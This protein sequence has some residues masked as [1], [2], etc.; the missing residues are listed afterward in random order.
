MKH[1]MNHA[2]MRAKRLKLVIKTFPIS[3][4]RK[5]EKRG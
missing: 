4:G 3:T 5:R 1:N 2:D